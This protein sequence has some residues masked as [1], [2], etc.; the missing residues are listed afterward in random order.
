MKGRP[1]FSLPEVLAGPLHPEPDF[2]W[3]QKLRLGLRALRFDSRFDS[4]SGSGSKGPLHFSGNSPA[5]LALHG[6][7]GVPDEVRLV[8]E[9]AQKAGL[10][11]LAPLLPGHGTTPRDLA[12]LTFDEVVRGVRAEFDALRSRGPVIVVGLSMG[13]LI[14]TEL[15][16][17]APGDVLGLGLLANAFFLP[18]PVPGLVLDGLERLHCPDFGMPKWDTDIADAEARRTH[19]SYRLQPMR[20]AASMQDAGRRLFGELF[21]V[22]CP[23]L[24]VHGAHDRACPVANA[25]RVAAELGTPDRRVVILPRSRH[26]VCR[27][28]DKEQLKTELT[29]FFTRLSKERART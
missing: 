16:L 15:Y 1:D 3:I 13:A 25:W 21:R 5:V 20:F 17:S 26:I 6:F 10:E 12:R 27:D 28:L 4:L 23:T 9:A 11:A 7:T 22:H 8:C 14:A 29:G 2:G 24:I 18:R 19:V